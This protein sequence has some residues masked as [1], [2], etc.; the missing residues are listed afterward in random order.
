MKDKRRG[1][2][3]AL[4]PTKRGGGSLYNVRLMPDFRELFARLA[5]LETGG[6]C[7][8]LLHRLVRQRADRR[9]RMAFKEAVL[10]EVSLPQW[11]R[12]GG[13]CPDDVLADFI[14]DVLNNELR[15]L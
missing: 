7:A 3:R 11:K 15:R 9:I 5:K 8:E 10:E 13:P 4:R 14:G 6:N 12:S 1:K 2:E